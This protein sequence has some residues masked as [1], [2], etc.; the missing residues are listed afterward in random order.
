MAQEMPKW[1]A[2][3]SVVC[4]WEVGQAYWR[5]NKGLIPELIFSLLHRHAE[6]EKFGFVERRTE[7]F[8]CKGANERW[9]FLLA[10]SEAG[11]RSAEARRKKFGSAQP[12]GGRQTSRENRTD[13]R[14]ESN[15]PS[16]EN[17]TASNEIEPSSS[18]S[19]SERERVKKR[20]RRDSAA[21]TPATAAFVLP[22]AIS[23]EWVRDRLRAAA[24]DE[25]LKLYVDTVFLETRFRSMAI[26]LDA[27]R[28]KA[29]KSQSGWTRFITGWLR[30]D[31]ENYR[32][33]LAANPPQQQARIYNFEGKQ[34]V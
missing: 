13:H 10:A 19:F 12:P 7:G 29:P 24:F 5:K 25:L 20:S 17:R 4:L 27:N 1:E 18:S 34:D 26:W 32:R 3:G 16:N 28:Q 30:R 15:D 31:W 22:E 2:I 21:V 33:T 6:L 23:G 9:A 14:T 11:K 8:Y